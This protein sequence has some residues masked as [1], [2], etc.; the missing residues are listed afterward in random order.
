MGTFKKLGLGSEYLLELELP[1]LGYSCLL[2]FATTLFGKLDNF[3]MLGVREC[4]FLS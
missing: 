3:L 4:S 2:L 1:N